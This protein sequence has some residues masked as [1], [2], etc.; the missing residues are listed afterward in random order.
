MNE[1]KLS[2]VAV[3]DEPMALELIEDYINSVPFLELKSSFHH[4]MKALSY[5]ESNDIDL[6]FIDINM[7][8]LTGLQ[9]IKTLSRKPMCILTTAYSEY[10]L[11]SYDLEVVDYLLKPIEFERFVTASNKALKLFRLNKKEDSTETPSGSSNESSPFIRL[12]S[13]TK[14][15][16]IRLS[17]IV[18]IESS[19]NYLVVHTKTGKIMPLM[20]M[21][22]I[23]ELLPA[24][25]FKRTHRS[26]IVAIEHIT[27][28]EPHQISIG[29][30]TIPISKPY[31]GVLADLMG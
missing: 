16:Q 28:L 29:N 19:G 18:Y 9:L 3:D 5:I 2:C 20:T 1:V 13:G 22:E 23:L 6:L 8:G 25:G 24:S 17:E 12:K 15:Y 21:S 10:A 14:T 11:T 4:P 31:R 30:T 26:F 27:S 7:P